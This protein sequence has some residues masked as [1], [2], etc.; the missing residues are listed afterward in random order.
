M[1]L[2]PFFHSRV[3]FFF[4]RRQEKK[5][6]E[7]NSPPRLFLPFP[8][9]H[10]NPGVRVPS[11]GVLPLEE[12]LPGRERRRFG[13]FRSSA[14]SCRFRFR[15]CRCRPEAPPA[16]REAALSSSSSPSSRRC[17]SRKSSPPSPTFCRHGRQLRHPRFRRRLSGPSGGR[18]RRRM[19]GTRRT[20]GG[21]TSGNPAAAAAFPSLRLSLPR[22]RSR[23]Q[24]GRS[25]RRARPCPRQGGEGGGRVAV[26]EARRGGARPGRRPR[27]G[28]SEEVV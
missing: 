26:E 23:R 14:S 20:R 8:S 25:D 19:Q 9:P 12:A 28:R 13:A 4:R 11:P 15:F 5:Q 17:S 21:E 3:A 24:R 10:F 2:Q 6:R 22:P 27:E 1:S 16:V 18:K 7:K